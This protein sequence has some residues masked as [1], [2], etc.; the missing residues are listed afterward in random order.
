M[1]KIRIIIIIIILILILIIIIFLFLIPFVRRSPKHFFDKEILSYTQLQ[2]AYFYPHIAILINLMFELLTQS[3][4]PLTPYAAVNIS[5]DTLQ[6]NTTALL[7]LALFLRYKRSV[8]RRGWARGSRP[9]R[10][11][12]VRLGGNLPASSNV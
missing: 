11:S 4:T 12:F 5:F 6:H 8:F 10:T 2:L 7:R 1:I 9:R 3:S